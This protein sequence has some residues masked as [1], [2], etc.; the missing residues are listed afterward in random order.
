MRYFLVGIVFAAL[1]LTPLSAQEPAEGP[2][3]EKGQKAYKEGMKDLQEGK[4]EFA[5]DEFKK[6]D[7]QDGGQCLACEK[8]MIKYGVELQDWKVAELAAEEMVA[9]AKGQREM[10]VSYYQYAIVL[11]DEGTQRHKDEY[12]SRA[13]EEIG[14]AL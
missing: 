9:Q 4:K 10:A 1:A 2:K 7:K 14:K 5:L 3:S 12:F 8:K 6:A 11:L 13:H